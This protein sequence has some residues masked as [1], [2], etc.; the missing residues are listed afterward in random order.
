[1]LKFFPKFLKKLFSSS[2][3]SSTKKSLLGAYLAG[4]IEGDGTIAVS[5]TNKYSP[6]III[7][8]C[9]ADLTFA[10]KLK[11]ITNCGKIQEKPNTGFCIWSIQAKD[12]VIKIINLVNG[13]FRT[14]KIEDLH[15]AIK[16]FK[17]T[18]LIFVINSI[19]KIR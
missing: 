9:K 10:K 8:F 14:P 6:K 18:V 7:A 3:S 13:Y 2:F 5:D 17:P 1:M 19:I 4:L 11:S 16:F 12:E 15:S